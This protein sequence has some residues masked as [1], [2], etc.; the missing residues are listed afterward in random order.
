MFNHKVLIAVAYT[1][2]AG[3]AT[4]PAAKLK[5]KP[6]TAE[7]CLDTLTATDSIWSAIKL[8][9]SAQDTSHRLQ[10]DFEEFF[11]QEFRRKFRAP[12][13]LPLSV[14]MG[15]PPCDSVGSRC[16]GGYLDLGAIAYLTAHYDGRLTDIEVIDA[17]LTPSL[18]D[19]VRSALMAMNR[20]ALGPT[21]DADSVPVI[22]RLAAEPSPDTVPDARLIF[23]ARVP[24]YDRPFR[25][26]SMPAAGVNTRYP[27]SAR[28][29]GLGDSVAI[30]FT[31]DAEGHIAAESL[32]LMRASYRDFVAAVLAA[33]QRTQ[34]HPARLG[35]CPV[36]TRMRQRFV[37]SAPEQ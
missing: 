16:V 12:S 33:L 31:V 24:R 28:L 32:E 2:I 30:A 36:S 23:R 1:F 18:A 29:A 8:S 27:F 21:I 13:K 19:S 22:V 6:N 37:F 5:T 4:T 15:T 17:T 34:Y 10:N 9:V 3:C 35:D 20:D 25:Y 11:A 26:A 7:G 14:I